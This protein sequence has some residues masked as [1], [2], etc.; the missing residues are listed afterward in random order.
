L[1]PKTRAPSSCHWNPAGVVV[2]DP[3]R[4]LGAAEKKA[5]AARAKAT[6]AA[7]RRANC[8]EAIGESLLSGRFFSAG[9]T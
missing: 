8:L 1:A 5:I 3:A 2:C 6:D 7:S 4:W 9:R